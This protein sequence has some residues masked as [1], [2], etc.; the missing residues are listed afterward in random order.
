MRLP[1][2]ADLIKRA[3][4]EDPTSG[5][6]LDSLGW[7]YFKQGRLAEAEDSLRQAA[8]RDHS[9]PTI[10]EH[11][12][13]VYFKRGKLDLAQTQWERSLAEW[14]NELP[15]EVDAERIAAI[16][17]KL[18]NVKRLIAQQKTGG[19]PRPRQN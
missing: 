2:A 17:S 12:G 9:D 13:D 14:H 3:L 8:A 1:E 5:A 6:F 16:E 15:A 4:A 10:L 19:S 7:A 11:L 18:T